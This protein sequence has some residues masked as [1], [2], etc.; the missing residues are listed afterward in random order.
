MNV[1]FISQCQK[2]ALNRTRKVLDTYANRIGDNAWQTAITEE[3]LAMV[4]KLLRQTASKNTAV[5]CHRISTRKRTEL[6]WI[7]GNKTHFNNNGFVPVNKTKRNILKSDW[8][9]NWQSLNAMLIVSTLSALLHDLGKSSVG[10]QNKLIKSAKTGD[11]YRHEWISLKLFLWLIQDCQSDNEIFERLCQIDAYLTQTPFDSKD[12]IGQ[13]EKTQ[14]D[15]LPP[16]AGWIAWLIATHHRLPALTEYHFKDKQK[17]LDADNRYF[18]VDLKT[19]YKS[20]FKPLDGWVKNPNSTTKPNE[21]YQFNQLVWHS[22]TWQHKLKRYAKKAQNDPTL[23]SLCLQKEPIANPFL[24]LLSRLSLMVGDHNYSSLGTHDKA[25]VVGSPDWANKLIANTD[26]QTGN[27]KQALD[28][29]LLGVADLTARFCHKLPILHEHLPTLKQHE[30]LQRNTANERF[31]W[32][33]HAVKLAKS[34]SENSQTHGFFGVNM[35]STGCGKTIGNARLMYALAD[36]DKGARLTIAL[37]LRVLTLQTG[38]SF[39]ENLGLN[40]SQLAVLVGGVAQKT[41]FELNENERTDFNGGSE[42]DECLL[43]EWVDSD[44]FDDVLDELNLGTVVADK[45]AQNLLIS[46]VVTCTIDHLMQASECGRGGK[47]IVPLLR[48]FGSDLI[49]DEPDDFDQN[50]LP[51]LSRLV[52]LAGLFGSRVLLSSATL[53]PDMVQG[54]FNAYLAGRK[55]YNAQFA[56]PTPQVVCAW[57]DEDDCTAHL[58]DSHDDF[59][60]AHHT[61]VQKR[62]QFLDKQPIKRKAEIL[63]LAVKFNGEKQGEF[64]Q[65]LAQNLLAHA[66]RLHHNHHLSFDNQCI[67]IGLMRMANIQPLMKLAQAIHGLQTLENQ[68]DTHIHLCVYHSQQVLAL[69]NRLEVRLDTLLS[70]KNKDN[71]SFIN[72]ADIKNAIAQHPNKKHHIFIV[73]AT[74]VAEVGRDHDYDWAIVEPSS[75]RSLVQLAGRVWRHRPDL[76][77]DTPNIFIWQKNIRALMGRE[78]CFTKPGFESNTHTL[79]SH[80]MSEL[81]P[82]SVL[83]KL[84]ACPRIIKAENLSPTNNL[85]DL[86]QTAIANLMNN[87]K[88]NVVNAYFAS[89]KTASRHHL[90]LSLLTPFR[91]G[92]ANVEFI[93][94]PCDDGVAFYNAVLVAEQG[95]SKQAYEI[96]QTTIATHS[97]FVSVWLGGSLNDELDW[98]AQSLPELSQTVIIKRF[99]TVSLAE[100]QQGYY[101]DE[102]FGFWR[103]E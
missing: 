50:D 47:Y 4:R 51:A 34:Q 42:S 65:T 66:Q 86:E 69:R 32:Q 10:F 100:H 48:L 99:A 20:L 84:D 85:A 71:Q 101:F 2:K 89:E 73:L 30:P 15:K 63:P 19:Y 24:T 18:K 37:G 68:D 49:L 82:P 61:F 22:P 56:K 6:V 80:D 39:R 43:D 7:V 41:L 79:A 26:R 33:N 46:P 60:K 83:D 75:V 72:Q 59:A 27:A 67:S 88:I 57:F 3:G 95:F 12:I 91:H 98:L 35:A 52:H 1:I 96:S 23:Q 45:S 62:G 16:I 92:R 103:K 54:L 11:P 102:R 78:I 76:Q 9:N 25:R 90:H 53:P 70:R 31:L 93:A 81:V 58:C 64:Y 13:I 44:D 94:K 97:P 87:D 28:E 5:S 8:Q 74:A 14:L 40:D 17:Y 38:Q 29:H 55:I 36:K 77:A 21:F